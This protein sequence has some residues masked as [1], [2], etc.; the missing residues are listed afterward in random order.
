MRIFVTGATGFVGS[1][2]VQEL[3][4]A[5]H[6]VLGLARSDASAKSLL[7]VGADV[8]RGSLEDLDSLQSGAAES[9]ASI[10]TAFVHDFANFPAAA[11]ID[12]L[13]IETL[14]EALAGSNRPLLVT[15]GTAL[16]APGRV[17]TEDDVPDASLAAAWPRRSEETALAMVSRGVRASSVRLPPSVHGQGDHGFVPFL[18]RIARE[19][20]VS[21]Y[22]GDGFN[23]WAAVRRLDAARLYRLA[24][25]KGI[26][27]ARY[28][29][30]GDQGVAL[31]AIAEII[32]RRL[33][34]PVVSKSQEEAEDH[35]G[36]LA[37]FAT[38]DVPA[39]SARTQELLGWEPTHPNL[40]TDLDHDY[41][42]ESAAVA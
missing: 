7:S 12:T 10:H 3:L 14:G 4:A 19:K 41:Y 17:A 33:G 11:K 21:A 18:I 13:A 15:S 9:D 23:R 8:H 30:V 31:R 38:I 5:G 22:V 6:R 29:G 37:R 26:A 40:I 16:V 2:V 32:G 39:S 1:A 24:L 20:G 36:W 28:H 34:V 35:F 27:G 25:E 42:F